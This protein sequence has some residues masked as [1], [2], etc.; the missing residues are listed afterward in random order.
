VPLTVGD[1]LGFAAP[2]DPS[3]HDLEPSDASMCYLA[4]LFSTKVIEKGK[5]L[6]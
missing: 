4:T 5:N 1:S 3:V 6:P 2:L